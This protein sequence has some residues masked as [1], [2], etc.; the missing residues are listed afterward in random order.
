MEGWKDG[1]MEGWKDGRMEGWKDGRMEGGSAGI[2]TRV[3]YA[4]AVSGYQLLAYQF[5]IA[6][7][8]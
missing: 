6:V 1:R 8:G 3:L 5:L 2:C 7:D 4:H